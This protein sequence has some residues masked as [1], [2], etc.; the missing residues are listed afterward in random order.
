MGGVETAAPE[1]HIQSDLCGG[2]GGG[3][4]CEGVCGGGGR[5]ANPYQ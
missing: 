5:D 4:E 2:E 3:R 1:H